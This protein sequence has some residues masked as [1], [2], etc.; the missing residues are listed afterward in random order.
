M[1]NGRT[2]NSDFCQFKGYYYWRFIEDCIVRRM[3]RRWTKFSGLDRVAREPI[4]EPARV[5]LETG[6]RV[7]KLAR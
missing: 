3:N 2:E 4:E 6:D 7:P 1:S 5:W